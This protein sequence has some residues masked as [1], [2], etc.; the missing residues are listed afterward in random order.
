MGFP[1]EP[2]TQLTKFGWVIVSP[3][4]ED[5]VINMLF[6]KT[7]SHDY[8]KLCRLDS[9]RI[10]ERW[11][12]SNYVYEEF[13]KELGRGSEGFYEKNLIWKDNH[14]PLKNNKS[15]CL[16]RLNSLVKNW[17][18]R[19]QLERYDNIVQDQIK[20]GNVEKVDKVC[21]Q[22]IAEGEKVFCLPHKPA[23]R[24]STETTKLRIVYDASSKPAKNSA[25]VNDCVEKG[26]SF[27]NSGRDILVKSRFKP[28]LLSGSIERPS[29]R[30][31]Y[32]NARQTFLLSKQL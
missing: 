27:Q 8:E 4:Q 29:Y 21:K 7:S 19:N 24:E 17:T 23:I 12:D 22:D 25:Y 10:K 5:R 32:R 3:G 28:I 9:L 31:E 18:H 6:S 14:P 20:E 11:D 26:S 16:D 1:V 30:K 13:R 15:N 2:I